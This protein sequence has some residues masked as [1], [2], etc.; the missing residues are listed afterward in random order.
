ME[1][2]QVDLEF[3]EARGVTLNFIAHQ[4]YGCPHSGPG[5]EPADIFWPK[6]TVFYKM[7]TLQI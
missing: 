4:H 6:G 2:A 3:L 7:L 5:C 1:S